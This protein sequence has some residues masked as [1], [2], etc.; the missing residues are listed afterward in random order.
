[1]SAPNPSPA[2]ER[3]DEGEAMLGISREA[4]STYEE[5]FHHHHR[6][7]DHRRPVFE[8]ASR[9][10]GG[11]AA[12]RAS[13]RAVGSIAS[14]F[15]AEKRHCYQVL[16]RR[17]NQPG[18]GACVA[19]VSHTTKYSIN[20][21]QTNESVLRPLVFAPA[22][23]KCN[24]ARQQAQ[25]WKEG[26]LQQPSAPKARFIV[27]WGNAPGHAAKAVQREARTSLSPRFSRSALPKLRQLAK[28][29][30]WRFFQRQTKRCDGFAPQLRGDANPGLARSGSQRPGLQ[31]I[32]PLVLLD[33]TAGAGTSPCGKENCS[34]MSAAPGVDAPW[35]FTRACRVA[36]LRV[37]F[38]LL[39]NSAL[40]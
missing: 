40:Q 34:P 18:V 23:A 15:E 31:W 10:A 19:M 20:R 36:P 2:D 33:T 17:D 27:A 12:V 6:F 21:R 13:R 11:N 8:P 39:P 30:W 9:L 1:M 38:S 26:R 16:R 25:Q 37:S 24:R 32:A 35:I 28:L 22:E 5:A 4:Q 7:E 3:L 14:C 29:D